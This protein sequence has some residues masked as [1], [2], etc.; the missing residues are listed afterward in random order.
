MEKHKTN[1]L[2]ELINDIIVEYTETKKYIQQKL[3][4]N[5]KREEIP[6]DTVIFI[7][8]FF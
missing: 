5:C 7:I 1:I 6:I 3:Q 8:T 2:L 4:E